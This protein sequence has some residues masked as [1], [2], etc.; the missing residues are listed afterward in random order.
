MRRSGAALFL[1]ILVAALP[2]VVSLCELRCTA[3]PVAASRTIPSPCAGHA[4]GNKGK[5]PRS[6][7]TGEHHDCAGHVL[8]AKGNGTGVEIQ[9]ARTFG[10]TIRLFGSFLVTPDQRLEREKLASADLSPPFGRS[11]ETLRL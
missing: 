5:V 7:P 4:A 8:L 2:T 3:H 10:A 11:T 1:S 6:V 9:L